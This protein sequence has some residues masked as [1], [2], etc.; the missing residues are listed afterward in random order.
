MWFYEMLYIEK[1]MIK[2]KILF[3]AFL[4]LLIIC[5]SSP[6]TVDHVI[7]FE[8][9]HSDCWRSIYSKRPDIVTV[10]SDYEECDTEAIP[11]IL[12]QYDWIEG[13][14]SG[15]KF[16]KK[17]KALVMNGYA[18]KNTW[19]KLTNNNIVLNK[20][21]YYIS[22]GYGHTGAYLTL[23][24]NKNNTRQKLIGG[25]G[26]GFFTIRYTE[27]YPEGLKFI[28]HYKEKTQFED[29][30]IT[31]QL[32]SINDKACI[33]KSLVYHISHKSWN[34]MSE[35]EKQIVKNLIKYQHYDYP[36]ASVA[37]DDGYGIQYVDGVFKEG[38]INNFG[39]VYNE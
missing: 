3:F 35:Q 16:N 25:M 37:T 8:A 5:F 12:D 14:F 11:N 22:G 36:W 30:V 27:E 13:D 38:K 29:S 7:L 26:D 1:S 23:E 34:N 19:L 24:G 21:K 2:N 18:K 28:I 39:V 31:P 15:V 6:S 17:K 9:I 4:A 33:F 20:G 10:I 32:F